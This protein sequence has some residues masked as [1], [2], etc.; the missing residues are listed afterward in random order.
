MRM[1]VCSV[2]HH[3]PGTVHLGHDAGRIGGLVLGRR[4]R[5]APR[6]SAKGK[7]DEE[8]SEIGGS[9]SAAGRGRN[10]NWGRAYQ[11]V[12]RAFPGQAS[13]HGEMRHVNTWTRPSRRDCGMR[14]VCASNGD[15]GRSAGAVGAPGSA[16][17]GSTSRP[18]APAPATRPQPGGA[19]AAAPARSSLV[20]PPDA[21]GRDA[22]RRVNSLTLGPNKDSRAWDNISGIAT[23]GGVTRP[24][25]ATSRYSG[26]GD[27]SR[28]RSR[29]QIMPVCRPPCR[30][31][32]SDRARSVIRLVEVTPVRAWPGS[33]QRH[34]AKISVRYLG[35]SVASGSPSRL[36][37]PGSTFGGGAVRLSTGKPIRLRT[38]PPVQ[39]ASTARARGPSCPTCS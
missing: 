4:R 28:R 9:Y 8:P 23:V 20:R 11:A 12:A 37:L 6:R 7:T 16:P 24:V 3:R 10:P 31:W 18:C 39:P 32:R 29:D 26:L 34:G 38:I 13:P 30:R 21:E 27:R 22:H 14:R 33:P 25:R 35:A 36:A 17:S 1:R 5:R 15:A 2:A 19:G